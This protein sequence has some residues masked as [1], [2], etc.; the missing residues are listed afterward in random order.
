MNLKRLLLTLAVIV[1]L[2]ASAFAQTTTTPPA[3][4]AKAADR[5]VFSLPDFV[6]K[7]WTGD[8]DGMI[9]R[10]RIRVLVPYSKTHYFVDR[11]TQRG[12]TY[13][14]VPTF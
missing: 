1:W 5:S 12:L 11:G 14:I 8:L 3:K 7:E 4:P 10:R 2:V 13:E 9:K 6:T